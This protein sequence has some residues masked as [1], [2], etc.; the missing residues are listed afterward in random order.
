M[1]ALSAKDCMPMTLK[2]FFL[3]LVA[4]AA[5]VAFQMDQEYIEGEFW[6]PNG[7][8]YIRSQYLGTYDD[9]YYDTVDEVFL[10]NIMESGNLTVITDEGL[11]LAVMVPQGNDTAEL[12]PMGVTVNTASGSYNT[13]FYSMQYY[14]WDHKNQGYHP[15][16]ANA[17][18]FQ[19]PFT[20]TRLPGTRTSALVTAP[21]MRQR[22]ATKASVHHG[23]PKAGDKARNSMARK[24]SARSCHPPRI[25]EATCR[26]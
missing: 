13:T 10:G 24:K 5:A 2:R 9:D 1:E 6:A 7:R 18:G 17:G 23:Q 25:D 15:Y 21:A 4:L 14:M 26:D 12:Q 20:M 8:L 19:L 11:D 22:T 16:N 3:T